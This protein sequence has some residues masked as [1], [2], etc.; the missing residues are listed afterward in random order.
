MQ[1]SSPISYQKTN[2]QLYHQV[3]S[4]S[5]IYMILKY[6]LLSRHIVGVSARLTEDS[7]ETCPKFSRPFAVKLNAMN[8]LLRIGFYHAFFIILNVNQVFLGRVL[9]LQQHSRNKHALADIFMRIRYKSI[10]DGRVFRSR[11]TGE[12]AILLNNNSYLHSVLA[13]FAT[14]VFKRLSPHFY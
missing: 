7:H 8:L 13:S 14:A 5:N 4:L 3:T 2:S 12:S 11:G 1:K 10:E 6:L 9:S